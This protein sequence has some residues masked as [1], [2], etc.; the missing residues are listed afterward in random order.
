MENPVMSTSP[1]THPPHHRSTGL[2][3]IAAFKLFKASILILIGLGALRLI[4]RDVEAT[5]RSIINH[6]RG[7]PDNRHLHALLA[8]LTAISPRRLELLGIGSFVYAGLFLT[9]GIGLLFQKRWAEWL[10]VI[11]GAG[12]IPLELYEVI[13]HANWRRLLVLA[14]N[15]AIVAYLVRELRRR[16]EWKTRNQ[17]SETR[18]KSE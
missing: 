12:F 14:I 9:E 18:S 3:V 17:K 8:K 2:M 6:F 4:H 7:D 11:S 16:Q 10:T 1:T 15:I 13:A 5:A